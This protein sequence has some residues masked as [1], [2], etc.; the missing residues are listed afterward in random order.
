MGRGVVLIFVLGNSVIV[1]RGLGK[2]TMVI[3]DAGD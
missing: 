3:L 2:I 1:C